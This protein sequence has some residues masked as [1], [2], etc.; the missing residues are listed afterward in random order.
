MLDVMINKYV[1][2]CKRRGIQFDYYLKSCKLKNLNDI[3]LVAI[4][5][6]LMDNA[7]TAA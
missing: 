4:L 7:V 1:I 5:G 2:D 3:D 6:N